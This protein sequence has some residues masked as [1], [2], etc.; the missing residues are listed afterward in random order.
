MWGPP[1]ATCF[2]DGSIH[3]GLAA[4][5]IDASYLQHLQSPVKQ[6][7]DVC[8]NMGALV[9]QQSLVNT[10]GVP[11]CAVLSSYIVTVSSLD[12]LWR[13]TQPTLYWQRSV[14][15]LPLHLEM[16]H[17]WVACVVRLKKRTVHLF[18]SFALSHTY[19]ALCPV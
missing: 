7:N 6:L 12:S 17:H 16:S 10:P 19:A 18:D 2:F 4:L 15:I 14:W 5:F 3:Q 11:S 1:D 9:L 13:A 8:I